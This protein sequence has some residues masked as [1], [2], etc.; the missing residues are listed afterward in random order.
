[1]TDTTTIS[2]WRELVVNCDIEAVEIVAALFAEI[3]VNEGVVIDEPFNQNAADGTLEIDRSRPVIVRTFLDDGV[4]ETTIDDIRLSLA[5]LRALHAIGELVVRHIG[6]PKREDQDWADAWIAFYSLRHVGHRIV[7]KAP[8]YAYE[9]APGETVLN[10]AIGMAFGS[11][12]HAS[13]HLSIKALETLVAPD[14]RVLD[15]GTGTGILALVAA[16]LGASAVDAVDIDP[17]AVRVAREN[18]ES[19]D[20]SHIVTIAVGSVGQGEPFQGEYDL[21]VAN[22]LAEVLVDRAPDLAKAVRAGGTIILSGIIDSKETAV[23]EAFEALGLH[24]VRRDELDDWVMMVLRKPEDLAEG[25]SAERTVGTAQ[26]PELEPSFPNRQAAG[27]RLAAALLAYRGTAPLVLAIPRGGVPVAAAVAR[28]LDAELDVVIARKLEVPLQPDL[29]MG[30][31]TTDGGLY[32][33]EDTVARHNV[34]AEQLAAVISRE[35]EEAAAREQRFRGARPPR[36]I[37]GRTVIVVDDGL[38]TGATMRA[39]LRALRAQ[40]PARL[41]AAVPVGAREACEELQQDADVV[42]CLYVPESF[43]A[44][45][46]YYDDF[47]APADETLQR[48]LHD[49][50][51]GRTDVAPDPPFSTVQTERPNP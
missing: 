24:L 8:W 30:A 43:S 27:E 26:D 35:R 23:R 42:A 16:R 13:T 5:Q 32:I 12:G 15:V 4:P 10:L 40:Q 50:T 28:Q 19:N 14:A 25:I 47:Q 37:A 1:V 39:T 46:V 17:V 51:T 11:G 18:A 6:V 33:N 34:T 36:Q 49:F 20:V 2:R 38:A 9:P 7:V 48:L 44:V 31:V 45:S 29:A 21:V 22:I 3:G 41:V